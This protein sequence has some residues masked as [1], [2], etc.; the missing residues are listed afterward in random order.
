MMKPYSNEIGFELYKLMRNFL[1]DGYVP[2]NPE[3]VHQSD[4]DVEDLCE[5]IGEV[6]DI[7]GIPRENEDD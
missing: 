4:G 5:L 2:D 3:V 6:A 1:G 7:M